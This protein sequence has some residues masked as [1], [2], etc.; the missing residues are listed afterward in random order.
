MKYTGTWNLECERLSRI[1]IAAARAYNITL[2]YNLE[3]KRLIRK[4]F[5]NLV[6]SETEVI[7]G[8]D[9]H[10]ISDMDKWGTYE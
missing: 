5:W 7:V 1:I 9:A 4:N 2:E 6:P 3:N 10:H 8:L